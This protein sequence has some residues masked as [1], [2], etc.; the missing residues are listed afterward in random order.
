MDVSKIISAASAKNLRP[1]DAAL[2]KRMCEEYK[3]KLNANAIKLQYYND[4]VNGRKLD[5]RI[6]AHI[7][8]MNVSPGWCAKAVNMLARRSIYD[9]ITVYGETADLVESIMAENRISENYA[10]A[11]PSQLIFG[12]GLWTISRGGYGEP[13]AVINYRDMMESCALWD[14]RKNRIKCGFVIEDAEQLRPDGA[15]VPTL[16]VMHTETD[17][18]EIESGDGVKWKAT[19]KPHIM[20]RPLMVA[21]RFQ[22]SKSQPFG[23]SRVSS[24]CRALTNQMILETQNL[25]VHSQS[26]SLPQKVIAGLSDAQFEELS[27]N[28]TKAYSTD[29]LMLT[30]N[31]DGGTP[32]YQVERASGVTAHTD[33]IRSL[34]QR[35]AAETDL[36]LSAFGVLGNSYTS[37]S[38]LR[39]SSDDLIIL[40][41]SMNKLN[42]ACLAEV[43][44]MAVLVATNRSYDQLTED[45]KDIAVQWRNP[46]MPSMAALSDAMLKQA[47]MVDW[48]SSTSVFWEQ[49]GYS[50]EKR[51]RLM[52]ERQEAERSSAMRLALLSGI[53]GN[54]EV[55]QEVITVDAN[56]NSTE[57]D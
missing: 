47:S 22:P 28:M 41:E 7:A 40:A 17:V 27:E 30:N 8:R 42:G 9:G 20:G 48:L 10:M 15:F 13:K 50:E 14:Y 35:F 5:K 54:A 4:E 38:A 37:E 33:I 56:A 51:M 18:I 21:M 1:D 19:Y 52:H 24:T 29:I 45:E 46:S 12:C 31:E 11:T 57:A 53:Q 25:I 44:K 2:L 49:L 6:P 55:N 16:I 39:A 26:F 3:Y 32:N 23:K 34:A 43:A 36:P